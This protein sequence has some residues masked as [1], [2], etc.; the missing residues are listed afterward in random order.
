ML[1]VLWCSPEKKMK[2]RTKVV[3][4]NSRKDYQVVSSGSLPRPPVLDMDL[5]QAWVGQN[6]PECDRG[7]SGWRRWRSSG[8]SGASTPAECEEGREL[9]W[10]VG[11]RYS[12][13]YRG[14]LVETRS[15]C[16]WGE[17]SGSL[18][19]NLL[20]KGR[21]LTQRC[22]FSSLSPLIVFIDYHSIL[23]LL[24]IAA[25]CDDSLHHKCAIFQ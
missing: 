1:P 3:W 12:P 25:Y 9:W 4:Q 7:R 8:H 11:V 15:P 21:I 17:R 22:V 20:W 6:R 2:Q 18:S 19:G 23:P 24:S 14:G 13:S 10:L 16:P 5:Q